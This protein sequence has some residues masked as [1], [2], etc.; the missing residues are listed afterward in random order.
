VKGIILAGGSGSR[1]YPLTKS[2]SKQMLPIYDKPMI[3]YPLSTQM[4]CGIKEFLIISTPD[5]IGNYENLL[6]NGKRIGCKINYAIQD[7][8]NGLAEAFLIGREFIKNSTV[9]LILGD[10]FFFGQG[11]TV[12]LKKA[13]NLTDGA[14]IFGYRVANPSDFGVVEFNEDRKIL[15]IEEKPR[16]PK[17]QYAIPGIYFYDN[18]VSEYADDLKP[19]TRGELEITDLNKIYL[20]KEKLTL[21]LFGRGMAWLD[22]GTFDGLLKASNFVETIQ[23]R[24]GFYIGCIEEIAY[25]LGYI[26]ENQLLNLANE[27][28]SSDYGKYLRDLLEKH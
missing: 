18:K 26:N 11:T 19:S 6:G 22:T 23:K 2:I 3:Y 21:A 5:D 12:L 15:S 1:L 24:Q 9:S 17:S 27:F 28:Q 20:E 13:T 10:N 7:Q 25:N 14:K 8:P 16:K 4:L